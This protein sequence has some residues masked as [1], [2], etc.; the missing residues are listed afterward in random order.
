MINKSIRFLP[1]KEYVTMVNENLSNSNSIQAFA[2]KIAK[3]L[4]EKG[5][6]ATP[7]ERLKINGVVKHGLIVKED[8]DETVSPVFPIDYYLQRV[9][10]G[11]MS[12]NDVMDIILKSIQE[13]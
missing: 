5:L 3:N 1:R 7:T 13:K 12:I 2:A 4:E 9:D 10:A 11:K 6:I 8:P